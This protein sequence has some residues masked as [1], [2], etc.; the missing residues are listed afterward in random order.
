LG[1]LDEWLAKLERYLARGEK[2]L[3]LCITRDV[4]M[5]DPALLRR[6]AGWMKEHQEVIRER[7]LGFAFVLPSPIARGLLK[8]LLWLQALPQAHKVTSTVPE[9]LYWLSERASAAGVALP[10]LDD[11]EKMTRA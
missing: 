10:N 8:A 6:S 2:N 11:V 4:R 3:T 1:Q 9:A 5:W 7:S